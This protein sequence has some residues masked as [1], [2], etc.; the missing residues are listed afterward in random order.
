[1]GGV[2][3]GEWI[4]V[5]VELSP[6]TVYLKLLISQRCSLAKPQYT[7]KELKKKKSLINRISTGKFLNMSFCW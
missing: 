2:F 6:F 4:H 5:Y 3:G 1:M 7:N